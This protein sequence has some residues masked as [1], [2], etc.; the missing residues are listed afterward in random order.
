MA[1]ITPE[2]LLDR[3]D[4]GEAPLIIDA[5]SQAEFAAGHVPGAVN[6][7]FDQIARRAAE[8]PGPRDREVILYCGHGPRAWIAGAALRYAEFRRIVY[9]RGHWTAWRR[10]RL[11]VQR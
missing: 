3:L 6:I 11:R 5:R 7:P 8:V 10:K 4:R 2:A 1:S 9:L